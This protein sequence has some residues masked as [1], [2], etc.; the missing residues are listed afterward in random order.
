MRSLYVGVVLAA[1]GTLLLAYVA[2]RVISDEIM[3]VYLD[4]VFIAAEQLELEDA[5]SA[6]QTHGP[7]AVAS[8][9]ARL[10]RLFRPSHYLLNANG[11]DVVSG[12]DKRALLPPPPATHSGGF[13]GD[14]YVIA[15]KSPDGRFWFVAANPK[16]A[17]NPT[18]LPYY[19]I[20]IGVA[21]VLCWLAA[22]GVIWPIRRLSESMRGFGRGDLAM[23]AQFRRRDE[24]GTLAR[25]FNDM[26]DRIERLVISERRL[27]Q[28]I[29]HEL[30][31]PLARLK[32]AIKLARTAPD[33]EAAL[34]RVERDVDRI[35]VLTA[36]LVEMARMEGEPRALQL[37]KTD[38]SE[39]VKEVA[40][41]CRTDSPHDFIFE[42]FFAGEIAC[43]REL[44]R[45]VLENIM[46]NAVHHSP[47]AAPIEVAVGRSD[48][49]AVISVR[50]FGP[51]VPEDALEKI[52]AP[53][54]R[55]DEAR[56][57]ASGGLGLGLAIARSAVHLH[58]GT[59]SAH[60][61]DPGLRVEIRLPR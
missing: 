15:H 56:E 28:D 55:V 50:D 8:Y 27:L 54:Y 11:I 23:R 49:E 10:D 37:E 31:S 17:D 38:L 18:F 21:A 51:G 59:I 24:I 16:Q 57:A 25:S 53:F 9:M 45:R 35:A 44:L 33:R 47:E 29:S 58:G 4:P 40:H 46:R 42:L 60:N 14:V 41:D 13:M 52:F 12:K 61:A 48:G 5:I 43:D 22:V 32:M 26:A 30:R 39:L 20:P 7:K 6:Y 3:E 34:D 2:F 19:L 36:E 1:L